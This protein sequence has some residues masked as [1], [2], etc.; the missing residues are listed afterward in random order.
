MPAVLQLVGARLTG[1]LSERRLVRAVAVVL[2]VARAATA[3]QAV[4]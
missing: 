4:A 1:R 3:V 2:L